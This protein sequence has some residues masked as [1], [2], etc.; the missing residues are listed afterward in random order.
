[1]KTHASLAGNLLTP[2]GWV[3]GGI[4]VAAGRIASVEGRELPAGAA[5]EPPYILPGFIDLHVHGGDGGES[6][7][8]EA[9]LR[10][11]LRFHAAHG[12][13]AMAPTTATS[14]RAHIESALADIALAHGH[15]RLGEATVLGA[16]LEGPFINPAKLGAQ[17]PHTIDGDAAL[18]LEWAERFPL[19]VATV[20]PE[21]AGGYE[22]IRALAGRNCRVQV[23]HSNAT[24][25]Q[26]EDAFACGC[27][28][29]T[30]LF[31]AM[32]GVAHRE[33]GVAAYAMA[34][35]DF[36]EIVCDLQHIHPTVI[37][38]ARRAIPRLYSVTDACSAAGMPDG[39]YRLGEL[40]VFKRGMRVTL[41][42]G[43]TLASSVITLA[44][45]LRN[46]VQIGIPL[47]EAA[48]MVSTR[49]ADYL[50]R[51]DLGRIAL[52]ARASLVRLGGDLRVEG[53]WIDGEEID[54]AARA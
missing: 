29:F 37:L 44:D 41:A 48:A 50:G 10:R 36:A 47:A 30:H 20:A 17:G 31:N 4:A 11:L 21:I 28:G 54:V 43:K 35:G 9:S 33:P 18:A 15:P 45:A 38:A 46:L 3:V 19:V 25:A 52:G 42:D 40:R 5:P 14:R 16:H 34:H 53:V 51:A 32:S 7:E 12:T 23:G 6:M 24:A 22:V 26:T 13:V 49:P 8:G 39:E 27:S 1:M 2:D